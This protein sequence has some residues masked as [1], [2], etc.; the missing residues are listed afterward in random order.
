V[1]RG[2]GEFGSRGVPPVVVAPRVKRPATV[3]GP[4]G[5]F[6][7]PLRGWLPAVPLEEAAADAVWEFGEVHQG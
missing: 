2:I 1:K 3:G 5:E 7:R 4:Y 6:R